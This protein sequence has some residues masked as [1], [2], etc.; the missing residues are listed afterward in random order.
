ML[1]VC[2]VGIWS[3]LQQMIQRYH[4][5]PFVNTACSSAALQVFALGCPFGF[6]RSLTAGVVSSLGREFRSL[7]GTSV[8]GGIQTDAAINP[9]DLRSSH[10]SVI[11]VVTAIHPS[12][13]H[14]RKGGS[15]W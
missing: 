12:V 15:R 3:F 13:Q 4:Q 2:A 9:G 14:E 8:P 1:G 10:P 7:V 11:I 6:E 5:I